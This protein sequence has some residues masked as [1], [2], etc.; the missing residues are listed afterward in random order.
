MSGGTSVLHTRGGP[1]SLERDAPAAT[2]VARLLLAPYVVV[3]LLV[4]WLPAE[5]AGKVT[6]I[7]HNA[8]LMIEGWGVPYAVGY[9]VLEFLANIVLLMPFG[10]LLARGWRRLPCWGIALIGVGMTSLIETVQIMLPTR[11]STVSDVVANTL[12]TVAGWAIVVVVARS[13]RRQS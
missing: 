2:R 10:V 5:Q 6:G 8:A 1:A 7:V 9:P 4:T 3:L 11:F 12:G 13:R